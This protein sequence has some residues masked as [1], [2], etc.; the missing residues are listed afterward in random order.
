GVQTCALPIYTVLDFHRLQ[1]M[2]HDQLQDRVYIG[3]CHHTFSAPLPSSQSDKETLLRP[4]RHEMPMWGYFSV[5]MP[6]ED[7]RLRKLGLLRQTYQESA[8]LSP[9]W[10][11]HPC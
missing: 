5:C 7:C 4:S 6:V 11:T 9:M 2:D 8:L 3:P 10:Q 1:S